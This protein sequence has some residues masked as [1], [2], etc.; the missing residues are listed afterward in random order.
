M[1]EQISRYGNPL[2][3]WWSMSDG[4]IG[5]ACD[6][7]SH[8]YQY[9]FDPNPDWSAFYAPAEEICAYLHR[10][11]EKYGVLRHVKTSHKVTECRWNE[12]AKKWYE[13]SLSCQR[14]AHEGSGTSR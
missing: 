10:V 5:C 8:S 9:S 11:A 2:L 13:E 14:N 7:P 12:D 1:G 6:I 3:M 4:L